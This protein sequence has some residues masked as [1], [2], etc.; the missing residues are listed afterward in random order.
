[1]KQRRDREEEYLRMRFK[2]VDDNESQLDSLR[3]QDTEEYNMIK[4]KLETDV[5]VLEVKIMRKKNCIT[6][7]TVCGEGNKTQICHFHKT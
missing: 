2:R 7:V 1:M 4:I 3:T 5:Q 6:I